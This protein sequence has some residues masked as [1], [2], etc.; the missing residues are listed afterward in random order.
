M[1]VLSGKHILFLF[2]TLIC[3]ALGLGAYSAVQKVQETE[4]E[5]KNKLLIFAF[6]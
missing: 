3:V 5:Q 4:E 2:F 6:P 1:L